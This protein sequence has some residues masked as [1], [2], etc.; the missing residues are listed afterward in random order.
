[1]FNNAERHRMEL[2]NTGQR[3]AEEWLCP[4]CGRRFVLQ[5]EQED[6]RLN[7]Q[8]LEAGDE[9]VSHFGSQGGLQIGRP[10]VEVAEEDPIISPELR[11]AL[12]ELLRD[13]DFGD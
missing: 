6:E 4:T 11:E 3:G 2:I 13:V 8:V 7:I 5:L 9:T 10:Q 12:N 1:M